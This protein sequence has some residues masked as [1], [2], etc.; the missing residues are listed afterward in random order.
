ML[1]FKGV[2]ILWLMEKKMET[3]G[4]IGVDICIYIGYS[5]G[6]IRIMKKKM[7]TTGTMGVI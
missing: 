6:C 5:G 7:E 2:V 3:T 1:G 4:I